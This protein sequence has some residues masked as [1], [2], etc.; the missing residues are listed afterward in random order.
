MAWGGGLGPWV[1]DVDADP[2]APHTRLPYTRPN[3]IHP[4]PNPSTP[5]P[6]RTTAQQPPSLASP[7][8][9]SSTLPLLPSS[10]PSPPPTPRPAPPLLTPTATPRPHGPRPLPLPLQDVEGLPASSLA[11][12][13]QQAS[14]E[15]HAG[16]SPEAGPW[17]FTLDFPSYFPVLTH[18]KNR[19]LREEMYRW[20]AGP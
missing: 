14:R 4:H 6:S 19:A 8:H 1:W 13:A 17:L 11:L 9:P 5:A 15:G 2:G 12:A 7:P 10:P 18:A 20:G 3:P 16:A